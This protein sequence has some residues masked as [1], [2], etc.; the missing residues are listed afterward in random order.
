MFGAIRRV[1]FSVCSV[2]EEIVTIMFN[3]IACDWLL[4]ITTYYD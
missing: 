4:V 3:V 1:V 2:L